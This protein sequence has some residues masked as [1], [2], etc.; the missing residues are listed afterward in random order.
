MMMKQNI[1]LIKNRTY[2]LQNSIMQSRLSNR[3]A[4]RYMGF[5]L[6]SCDLSCLIFRPPPAEFLIRLSSSRTA[7]TLYSYQMQSNTTHTE[8]ALHTCYLHLSMSET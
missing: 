6:Q 5:S 1:L 3:H 8:L 7:R 2:V 4:G